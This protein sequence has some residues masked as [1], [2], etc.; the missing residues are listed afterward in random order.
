MAERFPSQQ[1]W[2]SWVRVGLE[3]GEREQVLGFLGIFCSLWGPKYIPSILRR[4]VD[5]A[6]MEKYIVEYLW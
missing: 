2:V 6:M 3:E 4:P 5:K 1:A